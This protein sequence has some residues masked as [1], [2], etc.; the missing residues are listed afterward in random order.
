[1]LILLDNYISLNLIWWE[2]CALKSEYKIFIVIVLLILGFSAIA[3]FN[4]INGNNKDIKKEQA[5]RFILP[6]QNKVDLDMLWTFK[7]DGEISGYISEGDNLY[8]LSTKRTL[9]TVS[10]SNLK[11]IDEFKIDTDIF[12]LTYDGR[13]TIDKGVICLHYYPNVVVVDIKTKRVLFNQKI[14]NIDPDILFYKNILIYNNYNEWTHYGI[15]YI[16]GEVAWK[17]ERGWKSPTIS[18]AKYKNKYLYEQSKD[19]TY[20]EF[21]PET[22]KVINKYPYVTKDLSEPEK[23]NYITIFEN[24]VDEDFSRWAQYWITSKDYYYLIFDDSKFYS[25]RNELTSFWMID[26]KKYILESHEYGRYMVLSLYNKFKHG[27]NELKDIV[28]LDLENDNRP[29][30]WSMS[31]EDETF[32]NCIITNNQLYIGDKYGTVKVFDL[33]KLEK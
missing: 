32:E 16:T 9:Y 5:E 24:S 1:M 12:S 30:I 2:S 27:E 28:L 31:I 14:K 21:S 23:R 4:T 18:L 3:Y 17:C 6:K 29:I 7:I 15:N 26:F 25:Y 11:I 22:G 13:L 10:L 20:Y 8:I 33:S 19:K